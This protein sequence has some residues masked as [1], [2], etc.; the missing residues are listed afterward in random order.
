MLFDTP[1][2]RQESLCHE[3][4]GERIHGPAYTD[5]DQQEEQEGPEDVL[6]TIFG[7]AATEESECNGN[8]GGEKKKA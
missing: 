7:L 4:V 8:D 5:A 2:H 1:E 3:L 6:D